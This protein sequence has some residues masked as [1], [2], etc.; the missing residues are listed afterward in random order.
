MARS[1]S[2]NLDIIGSLYDQ[3]IELAKKQGFIHEHAL[4]CELAAAY[5][6]SKKLP[7]GAKGYF[8]QA[9]QSYQQWGAVRKLDLL[10]QQYSYIH[11]NTVLSDY[12]I[13]PEHTISSQHLQSLDLSSILQASQALSSE[14]SMNA[15]LDK[16]MRILIENLGAQ[17]GCLLWAE[18][19][20]LL[21][22]AEYSQLNQIEVMQALP[23]DRWSSGS[24]HVVNFVRK[25]QQPL[26]LAHAAQDEQF[27]HDAYLSTH[28][29]KSV[30]CFPLIKQK[31]IRGILYFENNLFAYAFK[32]E[33][34][35]VLTILANQIAISLEN[36]YFFEQK[37]NAAQQLADSEHQRAK[38]AEQAR[39]KQQ[40]FINT[41]CH[42]I[43]NPLQGIK[44]SIMFLQEDLQSANALLD[45]YSNSINPILYAD[46]RQ[47]FNHFKEYVEAVEQCANHQ[48][49]ITDDVLRLSCLDRRR[50]E[51][52]DVVFYPN[53]IVY[54]II[55]MLQAKVREK[56]LQI[57]L[58][59]LSENI[60]VIGDPNLLTEVLLN[61]LTNALRFTHIGSISI[62]THMTVESNK[63]SL[64]FRVS[65]TGVG[66]TYEEQ[67]RIFDGFTPGTRIAE[68]EY[69]GSGLGLA[70]AKNLIEL[71]G[72]TI[73]VASQKWQGTSFTF[74]VPVRITHQAQNLIKIS[75]REESVSS[76]LSNKRIKIADVNNILIV[77]DNQINQRI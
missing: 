4:A 19:E 43:R 17:K 26:I 41:I 36:A 14:T 47:Y 1:Q 62:H 55:K 50:I 38:E 21:L 71:M 13:S 52:V 56:N 3:A 61:L 44:G 51:R 49:V 32:D 33:H 34:L 9:F 29:V 60:S 72:G 66:M 6:Q 76:S 25:S 30:L 24:H 20:Q 37:L 70:I 2:K 42:E 45:T 58:E 65:D 69:G 54:S 23:F 5:W 74:V 31:L 18:D 10:K 46:I 67:K 27:S 12:L 77:E 16:I 11:M 48:K 7:V 64:S 73:Q 8:I 22:Q 59:L 35:Q 75:E 40:D 15:L 57:K 53:D 39:Q 63:N 68:K 28:K